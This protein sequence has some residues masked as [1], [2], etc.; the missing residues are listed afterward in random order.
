M[1][2]KAVLFVL[3]TLTYDEDDDDDP[4]F[5]HVQSSRRFW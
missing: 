1:V 2:P 3:L 4:T 5:R